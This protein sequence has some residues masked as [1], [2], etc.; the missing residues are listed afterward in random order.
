VSI[1]SRRDFIKAASVIAGG[2]ALFGLAGCS[3]QEEAP[4]TEHG[5]SSTS[6]DGRM[7]W[8]EM[9]RMHEAG[10]KAFPAKT[11]KMGNQPLAFTMDGDVKVFDLVV[12]EIEWETEPGKK[13]K[14]MAYNGMVP[15]PVIRVTEGDKVRIRV[16]NEMQEST[17]V[18]WHGLRLPANMDG[19]TFLTQPPITPGSTFTYEFVAKNPGTHM[20]HSHHNSAEQV[21][22][23][24]AGAFIIEPKDKSKEPKFDKDYLVFLNDSQLGYTINGKGFPAT[25]PY[26]AKLGERVRFRFFNAGAM[27][28]PMHLH[29]FH[30]HV[31]AK[32]GMPLPNP[33]YCDTLCVAP[34]ERYDAIVVADESGPWA[35]HCHIL[36][37]AESEHGMYGMTTAFIVEG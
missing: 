18:H 35:F 6:S 16:K 17:A 31:F 30:M 33:Y 1:D 4:A 15:G 25:E 34:G 29:G 19:V 24:L 7:D 22:R 2:V 27:I 20:Y 11:A 28:H 13:R 21:G 23:G 14:A 36:S 5:T 12:Q 9:D 8:K 3:K 26:T 10:M 32:D 37:H